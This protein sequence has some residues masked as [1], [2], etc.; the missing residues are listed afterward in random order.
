MRNMRITSVICFAAFVLRACAGWEPF[1]NDEGPLNTYLE[2]VPVTEDINSLWSEQDPF[3]NFQL[4]AESP[5]EELA[6]C[7]SSNN[8]LFGRKRI[9]SDICPD[10]TPPSTDP[11]LENAIRALEGPL[12]PDDFATDDEWEI[13]RADICPD[14]L[15]FAY[16]LPVC[17]SGFPKDVSPSI[18]F[19]VRLEWCTLSGFCPYVLHLRA[20]YEII[21]SL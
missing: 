15:S 20:L 2:P 7:V 14:R 6:A 3:L 21:C 13:E 1:F 11:D 16:A 8:Q 18:G 4:N 10:N 9:R 12:D 17:S 5:E 19:R